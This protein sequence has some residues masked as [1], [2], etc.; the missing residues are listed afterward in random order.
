MTKIWSDGA[1]E[2][3]LYW[4]SQDR[5]TLRRINRLIQDIERGG[6]EGIGQPEPLRHGVHVIP[7]AMIG[8]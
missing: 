6:Y 5:K 1:W 7:A 4:Q 8:P 2:D 3:Y